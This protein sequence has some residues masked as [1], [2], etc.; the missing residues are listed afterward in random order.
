MA[1]LRWEIVQNCTMLNTESDQLKAFMT[2]KVVL[3]YADGAI[4][5]K[6]VVQG[7]LYKQGKQFCQYDR[8]RSQ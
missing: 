8:I 4:R 7:A 1:H 2:R 6:N 3:K 5:P